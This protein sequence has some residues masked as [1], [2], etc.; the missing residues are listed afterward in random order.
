M[1]L[2]KAFGCFWGLA[3]NGDSL[4]KSLKSDLRGSFMGWVGDWCERVLELGGNYYSF[5]HILFKWVIR[6][7]N[8]VRCVMNN[9]S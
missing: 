5:F 2:V 9:V 8:H 7:V 6:R 4:R 1:T 3:C